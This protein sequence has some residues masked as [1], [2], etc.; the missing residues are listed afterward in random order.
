MFAMLTGCPMNWKTTG[1][2]WR[3]TWTVPFLFEPTTSHT[4]TDFVL[5]LGSSFK[6]MRGLIHQVNSNSPQSILSSI[7]CMIPTLRILCS[8]GNHV[9]TSLHPSEQKLCCLKT[10][11]LYLPI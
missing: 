4:S 7:I 8:R 11:F 9:L 5:D 1:F 10:K 2:E 3:S 6:S